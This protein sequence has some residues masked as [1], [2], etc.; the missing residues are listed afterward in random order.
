MPSRYNPRPKRKLRHLPISDWPVGD[1]DLFNR[2]LAAK[3][4]PFAEESGSAHFRPATRASIIYAWRRWLGWLLAEDPSV[5]AVAP[6]LRITPHRMTAF[7]AHLGKTNQTRSIAAMARF[8]CYGAQIVGPT[9]D[10]LWLKKVCTRLEGQAGRRKNPPIP[11]NG[12]QLLDLGLKLMDGAVAELES[13]IRAKNTVPP[14][15]IAIDHRDGLLLA[16][17]A[18][19]PLRRGNI[20]SLVIGESL[21][22]VGDLWQ[23]RISGAFVKNQESLDATLPAWIGK[24]IDEHLA[25]FRSM[26]F[27]SS[28]HN[29]LWAS[30]KGQPAGGDAL[31][32]AF[33]SRIKN[34]TGHHIRLH[35][36]RAIAVTTWTLEDPAGSSAARDLLGNRDP[37]IIQ[38]HYN[39]AQAIQASRLMALLKKQVRMDAKANK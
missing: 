8:L 21:V 33:T 4:D 7:F 3:V 29:G 25:Y 26:I 20:A 39:R 18:I 38:D 16:I 2:A 30:V 32:A 17:L 11:F 28:R 12:R 13:T 14:K 23:V 15:R 27:G 1:R 5:L 9:M 35:D 31:Y 37:R 36:V 10:W 19:F 22:K 24:R 34:L 6:A